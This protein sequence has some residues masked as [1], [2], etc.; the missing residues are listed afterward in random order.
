M[1]DQDK[2]PK[3]PQADEIL[4]PFPFF[5]VNYRVQ[6]NGVTITEGRGSIVAVPEEQDDDIKEQEKEA[7]HALDQLVAQ[8]DF[9][10]AILS[11]DVE[12]F[13]QLLD[14][15]DLSTVER[16]IKY[17]KITIGTNIGILP[18]YHSISSRT[19]ILMLKEC[20]N[21]IDGKPPEYLLTAICSLRED[22]FDFLIGE[23][24]L[25]KAEEKE[26]REIL[27][28]T[29]QMYCNIINDK[30]IK[31]EEKKGLI[32]ILLSMLNKICGMALQ[33]NYASL[34]K[35][36]LKRIEKSASE[37]IVSATSN[38]QQFVNIWFALY[39]DEKKADQT[40]P[41]QSSPSKVKEKPLKLIPT[42]PA[43]EEFL[44]NL[45]EKG[46]I[47][48]VSSF[49][50][51][52]TFQFY[53]NP[54]HASYQPHLNSFRQSPFITSEKQRSDGIIKFSIKNSITP[55]KLKELKE[56][57]EKSETKKIN[58]TS[59]PLPNSTSSS[60]VS[61]SSTDKNIPSPANKIN[62]GINI[63]MESLKNNLAADVFTPKTLKK[64]IITLMRKIR[65][66]IQ[67]QNNELSKRI[68]GFY[69]EMEK[70]LEYKNI[71]HEKIINFSYMLIEK[72]E[73]KK[74]DVRLPIFLYIATVNSELRKHIRNSGNTVSFYKP[75][76]RNQ[77]ATDANNHKSSL[78][79]CG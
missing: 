16:Y 31:R 33:K 25:E 59:T 10:E 11:G 34:V 9:D 65:L 56:N 7:I 21:R 60:T 68:K 49:P 27:T 19:I 54:S 69:E 12:K 42:S 71:P 58:K 52:G 51:T 28:C 64:L 61:V 38:K 17:P 79:T 35:E 47:T 57:I 1:Q 74:K 2:K 39:Y 53:L 18:I 6:R 44:D 5:P 20:I 48:D 43:V 66:A 30:K 23:K 4:S 72:W 14:K 26:F 63:T 70:F 36:C 55:E 62:E 24:W 76:N 50:A 29:Q 40:K 46:I 37:Y 15:N 22:V 13:S 8:D 75:S 3:K 45:Q 67:T 32:L 77:R 41:P 73:T 78:P